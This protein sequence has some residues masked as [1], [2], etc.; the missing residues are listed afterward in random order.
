[1]G[2][3]VFG[4]TRREL[5]RNGARALFEA[6]VP[7][8]SVAMTEERSLSVEGLDTNDL[9]I[10][11]LRELLYLFNS[12]GFLVCDVDILTLGPKGLS[13]TARGEPYDPAKHEIINEIKAVTYHQAKIVRT[14]VGWKGRFIVD[15]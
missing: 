5:F 10:N 1:M 8:G 15:V 13:L 7:P 3:D 2:F 4:R 9:W 14:G 11:T 12:D 6:I